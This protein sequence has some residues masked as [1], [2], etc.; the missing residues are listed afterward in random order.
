MCIWILDATMAGFAI[1]GC[2]M[3]TATARLSA[4]SEPTEN[5]PSGK[6]W[7]IAGPTGLEARGWFAPALGCK[8]L[9]F[10]AETTAAGAPDG[11]L[12]P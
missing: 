1:I 11:R 3:L 8:E 10:F 6:F 4:W 2:S 5:D 12:K 9:G 7:A